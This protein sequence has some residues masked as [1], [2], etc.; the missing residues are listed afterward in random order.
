M[1]LS[2]ELFKNLD[3]GF[4]YRVPIPVAIQVQGE[5][6]DNAE[7]TLVGLSQRYNIPVDAVCNIISGVHQDSM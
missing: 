5:Y 7:E 4:D 1:M 3:T 6:L 2:K